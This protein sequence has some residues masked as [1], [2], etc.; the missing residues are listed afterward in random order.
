MPLALGQMMY[1]YDHDW[2]INIAKAADIRPS[3]LGTLL[4]SVPDKLPQSSFS[5]HDAFPGL[6]L[7]LAMFQ[8]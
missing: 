8:A 7:F 2:E 5:K 4:H 6:D 1:C 3:T